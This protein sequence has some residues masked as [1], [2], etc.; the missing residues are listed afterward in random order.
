M[1]LANRVR[2]VLRMPF[3]NARSYCGR[4]PLPQSDNHSAKAG[5]C[6]AVSD[7]KGLCKDVHG[8]GRWGNVTRMTRSAH[9]P[10]RT[11]RRVAAA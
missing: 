11:L 5:R 8:L 6:P 7:P 2:R 3:R 9:D 1:M 4:N 10:T